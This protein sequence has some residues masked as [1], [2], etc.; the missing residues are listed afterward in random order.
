METKI[1]RLPWWL[2]SKTPKGDTLR[3]MKTKLR[4]RSLNTVCESARCPNMGVCFAKPTATF[5]IMGDRCTRDCGFCAISSEKPDIL[6]L[7]EPQMV[8][9]H[10]ADLGLKHVVVTSVTR[11]DLSDGGANHFVLCAKAIK[12]ELPESTVEILTPD[13]QGRASSIEVISKA[14]MEV[15]NHNLETVPSLYSKVRLGANYKRSLN[16]LKKIKELRP[17]ILTKSGLMVGLGETR[18]EVNEVFR[19][20]AANKV[21]AVTVGQYMRPTKKNLPVEEYIHPDEFAKM[22]QDAKDAGIKYV[23]CAPLVRSSFN[24]DRLFEQAMR[25][26]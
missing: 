23:V 15:F 12:A 6:D 2:V 24:A 19:D 8:A 11:D 25:K 13:F 18:D 17:E 7:N 14:R 3:K 1:K 4:G 22:E 21:E 9:Q 26:D 10:A 20:L 16:L 5:L